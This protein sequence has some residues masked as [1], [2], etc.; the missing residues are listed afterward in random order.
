MRHWDALCVFPIVLYWLCLFMTFLLAQYGGWRF[1]QIFTF[2]SNCFTLNWCKKL[3]AWNYFGLFFTAI[4]RYFPGFP[5]FL[6]TNKSN[7]KNHVKYHFGAY[8]GEWVFHTV[9][10][11]QFMG[12]EVKQKGCNWHFE[13]WNKTKW[14]RTYLNMLH[15]VREITISLNL[16]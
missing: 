13:K 5:G 6:P 1:V 11:D 14:V 8:T 3:I 9:C 16:S 7:K 2:C 4:A 12:H 15:M 10:W